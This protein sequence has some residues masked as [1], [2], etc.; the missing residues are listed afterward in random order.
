MHSEQAW[1]EDIF[2]T[3]RV[4]KIADVSLRVAVDNTLAELRQRLADQAI[5]DEQARIAAT[6]LFNAEGMRSFFKC[7]R[8][9]LERSL[10]VLLSACCVAL[11]PCVT[12]PPLKLSL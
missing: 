4:T 2:K 1:L 9:F 12:R 6:M 7:V 8:L 11:V 5:T 3:L 10:A